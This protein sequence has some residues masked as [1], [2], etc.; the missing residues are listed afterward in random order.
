MLTINTNE[1]AANYYFGKYVEIE[2]YYLKNDIM[3]LD[4]NLS[5]AYN[6]F[7]DMC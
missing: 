7:Y 2:E 4:V 6:L 5:I 1:I 3:F